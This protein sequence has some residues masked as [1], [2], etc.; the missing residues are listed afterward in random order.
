MTIKKQLLMYLTVLFCV[1]YVF[2]V[3]S[4]S[5]QNT[6][7]GIKL[8]K[9]YKYK[10]GKAV[11]AIAGAIYKENGLLIEF[12]AGFSQGFAADSKK[13]ERYEWYKEQTI[14]GRKVRIAFIKPNL[15]TG[16]EPDKPRN[17]ELGS[18]M[19]VTIPLGNDEYNAVNFWGEVL[20]VEEA[21]DFLLMVLTFDETK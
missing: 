17:A 2:S 15:K 20:T 18:I 8:L 12:E 5:A 14:N 13:K 11:D 16:W 3:C 1:F 7:G 9:G 4:I 6:Y 19:L 10:T 21:S